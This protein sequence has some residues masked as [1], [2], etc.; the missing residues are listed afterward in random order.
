MAEKNLGGRPAEYKEWL[1]P[2]RL[3]KIRDAVAKGYTNKQVAKM[4]GI[5]DSTWYDWKNRYTEFSDIYKEG[6]KDSVEVIA[7]A[8][9]NNAIGAVETRERKKVLMPYPEK[10]RAQMQREAVENAR[11]ENPDL[12]YDEVKAIER[13]VPYGEMVEVEEKIRQNKPDTAAQIFFLKNRAPE[14]WS[15]RRT[16]EVEGEMIT[17]SPLE[18]MSIEEIR[19]MAFRGNKSE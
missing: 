3:Q 11:L 18:N 6:Q 7:N 9:F 17:K 16:L 8:L 5:H 14:L 4:I 2:K 13:A 15:D 1:K 12:T 19:K 10:E